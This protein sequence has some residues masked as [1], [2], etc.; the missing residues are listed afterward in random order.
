M[1]EELQESIGL[2]KSKNHDVIKLK[3]SYTEL[4][5]TLLNCWANTLKELKI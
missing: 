1:K 2:N 4:N 3:W 5:L